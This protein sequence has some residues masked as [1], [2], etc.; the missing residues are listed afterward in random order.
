MA[1][2]EHRL[3]TNTH[4]TSSPKTAP[5]ATS[6]PPSSLSRR[7]AAVLGLAW[8]GFVL[9]TSILEPA[10]AQPTMAWW[11]SIAL[12]VQLGALGAVAAGLARRTSWAAGASLGAS[13]IFTASVFACPA[14]GHHM[15]GLWWFG[16]FAAVLAVA[17]LSA[18]AFLRRSTT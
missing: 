12:I 4:E 2:T 13:A 8:I 1:L 9:A 6:V 5:P 3:R 15:F 16:E 11:E 17:A 18:I 7:T 10:P 14:T